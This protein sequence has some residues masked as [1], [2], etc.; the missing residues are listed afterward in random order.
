VLGRID[1]AVARH[2]AA[3]RFNDAAGFTVWADH[4]RDALGHIRPRQSGDRRV[5]SGP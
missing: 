3:I 1:E 2:E 4:S 5:A